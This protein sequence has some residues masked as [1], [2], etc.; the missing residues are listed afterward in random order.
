M[1]ENRT[2]FDTPSVGAVIFLFLL[3]L[4]TLLVLLHHHHHHDPRESEA[5]C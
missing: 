4:L 2:V 3:P 1:R 5:S